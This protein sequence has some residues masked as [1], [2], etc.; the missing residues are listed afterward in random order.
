MSRIVYASVIENDAPARPLLDLLPQLGWR[1]GAGVLVKPNWVATAPP[2]VTSSHALVHEVI[3]WLRATAEPD[4]IV[5]GDM[6]TD[7]WNSEKGMMEQADAESV[8]RDLGVIEQF[9]ALP[10]TRLAFF[11][12]E[13][14]VTRPRPPNDTWPAGIPIARAAAE[15]DYLV[16]LIQL[17]THWIT[18]FSG[19]TKGLMGLLPLS[20]T[21]YIHASPSSMDGPVEM[22]GLPV[23]PASLR[24]RRDYCD[25]I[26]AIACARCPDLFVIDARLAF[27]ALGP[28]Q[29]P[30]VA[31]AWMAVTTDL[32]AA[33]LFCLAVLSW[34]WRQNLPTLDGEPVQAWYEKNGESLPATHNGR[35]DK[36]ASFP[37][38]RHPVIEAAVACGLWPRLHETVTLRTPSVD[39][40]VRY[41]TDA[42]G[43]EVGHM[44]TSNP[45]H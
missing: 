29:G 21:R 10:G 4:E 7:R 27:A 20:G 6:P 1:P 37:L 43:A 13:E 33:D 25:R 2:P 44:L 19:S 17:K 45:L 40:H 32:V 35:I 16:E 34:T 26:A 23:V 28:G 31:P 12:R 24:K 11:D 30:V 41:L 42:M 15:C 5:L 9:G 39:D 3:A 8:F 38:R 36:L 14:W 22:P 18:G